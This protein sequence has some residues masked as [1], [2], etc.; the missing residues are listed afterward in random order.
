MFSRKCV[1]KLNISK[2]D[3]PLLAALS[4]NG[5]KHCIFHIE[6]VH[7]WKLFNKSHSTAAMNLNLQS[8]SGS[9]ER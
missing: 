4:V 5:L 8:I 9:L 2:I 1:C 6:R 7:G 3:R